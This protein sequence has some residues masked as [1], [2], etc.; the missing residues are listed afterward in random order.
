MGSY[1][2]ESDLARMVDL[3]VVGEREESVNEVLSVISNDVSAILASTECLDG[4]HVK[5]S[6]IPQAVRGWLTNK[7]EGASC[8]REMDLEVC[9]QWVSLEDGP[10]LAGVR[11]F[12]CHEHKP[13][14]Q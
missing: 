11:Y 10:S 1:K 4:T 2:D 8:A 12:R 13:R 3:T 7:A 9:S 5:H 14:R 6:Q